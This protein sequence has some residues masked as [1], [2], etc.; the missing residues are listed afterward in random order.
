ML[1]K[2]TKIAESRK[3]KRTTKFRSGLNENKSTS[4]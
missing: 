4:I 2:Q 1:N 3:I